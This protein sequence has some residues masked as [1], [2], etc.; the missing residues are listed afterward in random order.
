MS[1]CSG[2]G[3]TWR[4]VLD[5]DGMQEVVGS[6]RSA[7]FLQ[8]SP[9]RKHTDS[10]SVGS[11]PTESSTSAS[12]STSARATPALACPPSPGERPPCPVPLT[13]CER[14]EES[15]PGVGDQIDAFAVGPRFIRY[16]KISPDCLTY[17]LD[18]ALANQSAFQTVFLQIV[19]DLQEVCRKLV[20]I[21]FRQK[22]RQCVDNFLP[23]TAVMI[24][25]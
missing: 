5:R 2:A 16:I 21:L 10:S 3:E 8:L 17:L 15:I 25:K 6:S 18:E 7:P 12:A 23:G 4:L 19:H 14:R 20:P 9:F 1:T 13:A 11:A 24:P 22:H